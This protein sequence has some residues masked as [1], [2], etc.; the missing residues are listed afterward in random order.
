M[1]FQL[2]FENPMKFETRHL[3]SYNQMDF[4]NGLLGRRLVQRH[5]RPRQNTVETM[6]ICG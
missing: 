1:E 2:M 3:V 5:S 4:F 6:R